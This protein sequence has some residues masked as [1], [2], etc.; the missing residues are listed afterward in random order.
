MKGSNTAEVIRLVA[1]A[2]C[3]RLVGS[4]ARAENCRTAESLKLDL[5]T[6]ARVILK[7]VGGEVVRVAEFFK[8]LDPFMSQFWSTAD[9]IWSFADWWDSLVQL[10]SSFRVASK[11]TKA[12][13]CQCC[14]VRVNEIEALI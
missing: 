3:V 12:E 5:M 7:R 13:R 11:T 10:F 1:M 14:C 4:G 8:L 9:D 6:G 2:C